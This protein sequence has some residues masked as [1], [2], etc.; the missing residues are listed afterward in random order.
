MN[1]SKSQNFIAKQEKELFWA[2]IFIYYINYS[3]EFDYRVKPHQNIHSLIDVKAVS[4]SEKYPE[5]NMQLTW[6]EEFEFNSNKPVTKYLFFNEG[7]IKKA[8]ER[9]TNEYIKRREK[10]SNIILLLQGYMAKP[11]ANDILTNEFCNQYKSSPFKGI[12]YLVRPST[13]LKGKEHP[14]DGQ[15]LPIKTMF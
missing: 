3:R 12:Y 4:R 13:D 11:W 1:K 5:L 15:I 6:V 8:I 2:K 10:I 7:N 14:K 9:K